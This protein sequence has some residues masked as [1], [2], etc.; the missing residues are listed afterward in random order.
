MSTIEANKAVLSEEEYKMCLLMNKCGQGHMFESWPAPGT[1]DSDKKALAQQL[2]ALDV[3]ALHYTLEHTRAI[4][5]ICATY[6]ILDVYARTHTRIP[7]VQKR[8]HK[9]THMHMCT[10]S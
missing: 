1:Q 4:V 5:L 8:P 9:R 10:L 6:T 7:P 2:V 3:R